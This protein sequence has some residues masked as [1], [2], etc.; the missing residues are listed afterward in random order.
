MRVGFGLRLEQTQKLIMTPELR[1]AITILQL[2]TLELAEYLQEQLLENP[3]LEVREEG[4]ERDAETPEEPLE[5]EGPDLD[6]QEYFQDGTDLGYIASPR[7]ERQEYSYEQ[8]LSGSQTLAEHLALQLELALPPG[9]GRQVG[10]FLIGNLDEHGYLC[11]ELAEVAERFSCSEQEVE[12]VLRI[13]QGF[14]P[15]GV[16]ARNLQECLLLQVAQ[17]E[18]RHPL[19]EELIRHYLR[20]LAEGRWAHIAQALGTGVAE[21]QRAV[22]FIRTLDPKPGRSFANPHQTRYIVPDA[23]V[24]RVNGDYVVLVNDS[25]APRL[26][27][28]PLYQSLLQGHCDEATR[29]FVEGKLNAAT[30]ILRSIEQRRLTLYRVVE[31]IVQFQREFLERGIKYLR[32][33]NLKQVAEHLGLHESTISRATAGKYVQTPQGVFE[34]KFFFANGLSD[35]SGAGTSAESIKKL[36]AEFVA[37]EDPTRPYTDQVI[38]RH[39][40]GLGINI[41]RRTVAKYRDELGIPSANRR[42]RFSD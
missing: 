16:G 22:D 8:Y 28:N 3:V 11:V 33:L 37:G 41:S 6:W 29:R 1:Q 25:G 39:L 13:L 31:C 17:R 35:R 5:A 14:D 27:I 9:R 12:E 19:A 36:L 34:L 30:W 26:G 24:E 15:P 32:P 38:T 40:Q 4:G 10:F 18:D 42:R 23:V 20:D 2:S 21:V 7:E